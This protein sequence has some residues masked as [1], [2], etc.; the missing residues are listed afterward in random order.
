M[1]GTIVL[2]SCIGL[3]HSVLEQLFSVNRHGARHEPEL[4][5]ENDGGW[6]GELSGVGMRQM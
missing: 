5:L 2:L 3:A 4:L 1:K 6:E